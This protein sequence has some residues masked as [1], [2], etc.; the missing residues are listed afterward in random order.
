MQVI[1]SNPQKGPK[2]NVYRELL[3]FSRDNATVNT[4]SNIVNDTTLSDAGVIN[5]EQVNR[6]Q[7]YDAS[8]STSHNNQFITLSHQI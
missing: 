1:S 3:F 4:F 6:C 8:H 2:N 5:L 7:I